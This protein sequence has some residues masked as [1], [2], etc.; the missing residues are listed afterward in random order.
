MKKILFAACAA[1][2]AFAAQAQ[3]TAPAPQPPAGAHG[4]GHDG[5]DGRGMRGMRGG[6][7]QAGRA[8]FRGI[9]LTDAQKS[10][11]KTIHEKYAKQR[12][13]LWTPE[14]GADGRHQ[15]PDSATR[16]PSRTG[17]W[18]RGGA[19]TAATSCTTT[20]SSSAR[21]GIPPA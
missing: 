13:T 20:S 14:R 17:S 2:F 21:P 19:S 4:Q 9:D 11:V 15:R 3:T 6:R 5:H 16:V 1:S 8:L 10:Q 18:P 7:G 12:Q